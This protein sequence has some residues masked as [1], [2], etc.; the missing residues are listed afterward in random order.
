V[1]KWGS[2][3]AIVAVTVS[4]LLATALCR[5]GDFPGRQGSGLSIPT[6]QTRYPGKKILLINSY[7]EGYEWSD[8]IERGVLDVLK[9]T[10]VELRFLRLDTK[11]HDS[12]AFGTQAGVAAKAFIDEFKPDVVI[13]ADDNAQKYVV[14]PYLKD[15]RLPVVF[16]G[17]NWDASK[18]GY[19]RE[20][21]TGMIEVDMF[22]ELLEHLRR[23][24]KGD[25]VGFLAA[26]VEIER[27]LADFYNKTFCSGQ[28]K[29]YL[30][31][32]FEDWKQEFIRAQ[33]EVDVLV[34]HNNAGLADWDPTSAEAFI[35]QE[36]K[37]PLGSP[38]PWMASFN[39]L[40]LGIVPEEQGEY[41]ALTALRILGGK[42]PSDIPLVTNKRAKLILNMRIAH[43]LGVVFDS[44]SLEMAE[45]IGIKTD[46]QK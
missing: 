46:R 36:V 26:D 14:V 24:A 18:Y 1:L 20:N 40:T 3:G 8:G 37:I 11:R 10:D 30:T 29:I 5:A 6:Q 2:M 31:K 9:G 43:R 12:E 15:N 21:V 22:P 42:K 7:H 45:I 39:L 4:I 41:A 34:N 13:A 28:M 38:A 19:P 33:R 35:L 27:M 16:C 25:R 32:T 17:V 44:A 23:Y